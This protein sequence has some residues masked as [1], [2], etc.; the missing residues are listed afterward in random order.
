VGGVGAGLKTVS[1]PPGAAAL[2]E[3]I[4]DFGYWLGAALAD[5]VDNSIT[6]HASI[7]EVETSMF[8]ARPSIVITDDGLGMSETELRTAMVLGSQ[9]PRAPRDKQD[10]GRFGLGL[11]T[12]SFSQCRRL[13]V[14]TRADK[15]IHAAR[16]DLDLVTET[17]EWLL[18]IPDESDVAMFVNK[19]GPT[20]T[21]VVWE[22]LDRL[23][24]DG[25]DESARTAAN[26]AIDAAIHHLSLVFHRF[27][28]G[29]SGLSKVRIVVNG[30]ALEPFDP[31]CSTDPATMK[32]PVEPVHVGDEVVRIQAFTLPHHS[33]VTVAEWE[34]N[35]GPEGYLRN[36][37]FYVYRG[38]RL[39]IHG[40]WFRLARQTTLTQLCR[41]KIDLPN[42][43]DSDWKIDVKKASAQPPQA[44]RQRLRALIE[45]LGSPSRRVYVHRGTQLAES[46]P[47]PVWSR[48]QKDGHITF[49]VNRNHPSFLKAQS[50][51]NPDDLATA[52]SVIESSLPLDGLLADLGNSPN[53]VTN[54][55]MSYEELRSAVGDVLALY[56]SSPE[57][58]EAIFAIG[59]PFRSHSE[60]METIVAELTGELANG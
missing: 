53:E 20:G 59:E 39:I 32:S 58:V 42:S 2:M 40:T 51:G 57:T 6:K 1:A 11:K 36:Q 12:A 21:V 8:D 41:V 29:E 16:W 13:T 46:N 4:R 5:I 54:A 34:R 10:L 33:K 9:D 44:V 19:I 48:V 14:V 60:I 45:T 30:R 7:I 37:G 55:T 28:K 15:S 23:L 38:G 49:R 18:E 3:G 31:F 22:Q 50:T 26:E 17:D 52:L 43:L 24:G 25:P 47:L 56:P 35:A 27:L